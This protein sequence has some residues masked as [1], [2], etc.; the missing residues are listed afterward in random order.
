MSGPSW[1]GSTGWSG[2]STSRGRGPGLPWG[3]CLGPMF[4]RGRRAV[5][6]RRFRLFRL[7]L[8]F[9]PGAGSRRLG[10]LCGERG[11]PVLVPLLGQRPVPVPEMWVRL[12][13]RG[14]RGPG[15]WVPGSRPLPSGRLLRRPLRPRRPP[16]R[17]L[18]RAGERLA[19]GPPRRPREVVGVLV[20]GR[21][22]PL[23]AGGILR[24]RPA[25]RRGLD[26][27]PHPLTPP[28][29][30]RRPLPSLLPSR[31]PRAVGSTPACCGRT[32]WRR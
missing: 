2:V 11:V 27:H 17:R 12:G 3:T 32:S 22:R 19:P 18:L 26:P 25:R 20:D 6:R 28:Q 24:P 4:M 15:R 21:R 1:P 7:F 5:R 31:L 23:R 16:R 14:S 29:S 9:R 10:P 13:G 8:L 30:V